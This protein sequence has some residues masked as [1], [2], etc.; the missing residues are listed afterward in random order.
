MLRIAYSCIASCFALNGKTSHLYRIDNC[1]LVN[2]FIHIPKSYFVALH[3][4]YVRS[5]SRTPLV[6]LSNPRNVH[7]A[8][9]ILQ[10][11]HYT[12]LTF[13]GA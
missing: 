3:S 11:K 7:D 13:D 6:N 12:I 4:I 5:P 10:T 8:T 2:H 9:Q 1:I